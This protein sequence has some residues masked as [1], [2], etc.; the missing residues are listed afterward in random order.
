MKNFVQRTNNFLSKGSARPFK[1]I[2]LWVNEFKC[3]GWIRKNEARPSR[4]KDD[5]NE[6][7]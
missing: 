5:L 6:K 3:G 4:L 1:T 2:F 7:R